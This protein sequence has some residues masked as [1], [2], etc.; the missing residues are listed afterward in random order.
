MVISGEAI[1]M[2]NFVD[3]I[4]TTLR[5]IAANIPFMTEE[6]RK[7]LADYMRK[8]EPSYPG[9]IEKLEKGS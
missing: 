9:M 8:A 1:R 3:D 5:R 4:S 6:E 7:R 2:M